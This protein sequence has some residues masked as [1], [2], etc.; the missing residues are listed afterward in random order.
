MNRRLLSFTFTITTT[1]TAGQPDVSSGS[2]SLDSFRPLTYGGGYIK[3]VLVKAP[4]NVPFNFYIDNPNGK[5]CFK[6]FE[7]M[8][9]IADDCDTPIP[10]LLPDDTV[11]YTAYITE[12][13]QI[14]D[15]ECEIIFAEVY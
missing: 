5:K 4:G 15:Y 11:G 3:Q 2:F 1:A 8:E 7:A 10:G 13:G 6:R 14:G 9:E 12:A